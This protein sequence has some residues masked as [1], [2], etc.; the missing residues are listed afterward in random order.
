MST[1]FFTL[2]I[3]FIAGVYLS[4]SKYHAL[5]CNAL[6]CLSCSVY[7]YYMEGYAGI[8]ACLAAAFGSLYQLY[9]CR[10]VNVADQQGRVMLYKCIGSIL[11][12]FVGIVAVYQTPA[13]LLLVV[14]IIS[15]RGSEMLNTDRHVKL[16]YL[17]AESM[18]FVYAA[19]NELLGMYIVHVV[20]ICL[21]I[22]TLY[23]WPK[24]QGS[25]M[26]FKHN[27]VIKNPPCVVSQVVA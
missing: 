17:L 16:G 25:I 15:S 18:W 20:M 13:D 10:K 5:L 22:F 3:V 23:I 26:S 6:C 14:A 8:V 12:T 21:G 24:L 27:R 1:V 4:K 9:I 11:F 19:N 2:Y 7:L